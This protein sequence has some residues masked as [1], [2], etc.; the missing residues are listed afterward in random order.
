[1]EGLELL[2]DLHR[3]ATRQGPGGDDET[4]L[5]VALSSLGNKT[6]L[7]IADIGCGSGASTLVLAAELDATMTAVDF[8]P[9]FLAELETATKRAGLEDRIKPLE[10]SMD[11]LPFKDQQ[12]DAIWAEGAIYNIGFANGIAS[13]RRFLKPDGILA[14][15]EL[16]WLT[17]E[18]PDELQEHWMQEY[19]E[20]GTAVEKIAVLEDNGYSPI[21]YFVLPK[22]CWMDNYYT[23]MRKRFGEF[24]DRNGNT[25]EA[26]SV[27]ESEEAEISL[28][29]KYSDYVSYGFYVAKRTSIK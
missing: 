27:V 5:A 17:N 8:L 3:T 19:P 22:H 4:R 20:V 11:A 15:S 16:T 29:E 12:F 28:Y 23:P 25:P 10:A 1:M 6:G 21:G 26:V 14:V 9:E 18:R 7:Q 13:W 24:L 2:I